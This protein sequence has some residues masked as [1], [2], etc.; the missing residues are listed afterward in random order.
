M[1]VCYG[2]VVLAGAMGRE[3]MDKLP[4]IVRQHRM[5]T[6]P[7][8]PCRPRCWSPTRPPCWA[9]SIPCPAQPLTF[10]TAGLGQPDDVTL[11]PYYQMHHQRYNLYWSVYTPE[12]WAQQ[13]SA[14]A[15]AQR[16]QAA[17]DARAVD[18]FRPGD[19][20][21]EVDHGLQS[22]NSRSGVAVDRA[23]RDAADGWFSFVLKVDPVAP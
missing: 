11:I 9:T 23:W 6:T 8:R 18:V 21:S 16:A 10:R 4:D 15:D 7:C 12:G 13:K 1:A 20:Q 5:R 19:Q 14:L 3:G 22:A 17:Q 2:P